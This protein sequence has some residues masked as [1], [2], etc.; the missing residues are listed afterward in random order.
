MIDA[1]PLTWPVSQPRTPRAERIQGRFQLTLVR[2]LGEVRHNLYLMGAT[3]LVVSSNCPVKRD[4]LPYAN[5]P[6][7]DDPGVAV[8]FNRKRGAKKGQLGS[9]SFVL[10]C[11]QYRKLVWNIR[12]IGV[13]LESLRAIERHGSSRMLEQAFTGFAALPAPRNSEKLWWE[14]L[15]VS[16]GAS[17]E[18]IRVAYHQLCKIHHPDVG[19]D[20]KWMAEINRAFEQ[21][22]AERGG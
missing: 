2:S 17:L 19:G 9:Q 5:S 8:Y 12:A 14:V 4:N 20:P 13:T 1:F 11:D 18:E 16:H 10:A 21:A 3:D 15:V 6:E 7:P 22:K